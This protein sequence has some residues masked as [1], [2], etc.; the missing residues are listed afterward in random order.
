VPEWFGPKPQNLVDRYQQAVSYTD[1]FIGALDVELTR[2]NL[3]NDTILCVVGD[4]G[5]GFGEHRMMGHERIPFDEVLRVVMC[6]RA[7]F[8]I[9]PGTRITEPVGS[10]DLTPTILGLLGFRVEQM[11]FDGVNVFEPIPKDRRVYFSGWM[12]QGPSGFVQENKKFVYN[13]ERGTVTLYQI[14]SD[15]LELSGLELPPGQTERL[16]GEIVQWRKSTIFRLGPPDNGQKRLFGSWLCRW[17][18]RVS[19]VKHEESKQARY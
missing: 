6:L 4:H 12:Q 7:P 19:T 17:N 9:E 8:L 15:P 11:S 5:E 14:D 13:P 16:S 18:G 10:V 1:R 2:L 3:V